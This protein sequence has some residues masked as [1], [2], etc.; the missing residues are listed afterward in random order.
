MKKKF[1]RKIT[2]IFCNAFCLKTTLLFSVRVEKVE[3]WLVSITLSWMMV[4]I[5]KNKN[6]EVKLKRG[7][8]VEIL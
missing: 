7:N 1:Q 6:S 2:V 8:E 5:K 4:L 3:D